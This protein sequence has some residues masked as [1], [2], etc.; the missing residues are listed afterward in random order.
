MQR[1][2][3]CPHTMLPTPSVSALFAKQSKRDSR[4]GHEMHQSRRSSWQRPEK[5]E[6]GSRTLTCLLL[7]WS[8]SVRRCF[9]QFGQRGAGVSLT[10]SRMRDTIQ[11]GFT[12]SCK[13]D[14]PSVTRLTPLDALGRCAVTP[15]RPQ[16]ADTAAAL[17]DAS[18]SAVTKS[19]PSPTEWVCGRVCR[20]GAGPEQPARLPWPASPRCGMRWIG[21]AGQ[22]GGAWAVRKRGLGS[23]KPPQ[24]SHCSACSSCHRP[25]ACTQRW[26]RWRNSPSERGRS[27][28]LPSRA[29][30][31]APKLGRCIQNIV[32]EPVPGRMV[33]GRHQER[34][35]SKASGP[36]V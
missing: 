34:A 21:T 11:R 5:L 31:V 25:P 22:G 28:N 18:K 17:G 1:E 15:S 20:C 24:P 27:Q 36:L 9:S 33:A 13:G 29:P 19:A 2:Q 10:R 6:H 35:S 14:R 7:S 3:A 26:L 30:R 16:C 12:N 8:T 4:R 23:Y 32:C